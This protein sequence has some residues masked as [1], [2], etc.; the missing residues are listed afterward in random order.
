MRLA[1]NADALAYCK[2]KMEKVRNRVVAFCPALELL[3]NT[4]SR[5]ATAEVVEQGALR[6][7]NDTM[8]CL[9][10]VMTPMLYQR[11]EMQPPSGAK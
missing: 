2:N 4:L 8:L 5:Q 3:R 1:D 11:L 10:Q 9:F 6:S 7:L